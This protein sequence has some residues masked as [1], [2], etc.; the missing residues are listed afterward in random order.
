MNPRPY[1][2]WPLHHPLAPHPSPL[3][4]SSAQGNL[5]EN[6]FVSQRFFRRIF[7]PRCFGDLPA[8]AAR[9]ARPTPKLHGTAQPSW[10]D[11]LKKI[12][13]T[14][15][16]TKTTHVGHA[17]VCMTHDA[18]KKYMQSVHRWSFWNMKEPRNVR[19]GEIGPE[20]FGA[21]QIP[22]QKTWLGLGPKLNKR[23]SLE[24]SPP[25]KTHLEDPLIF[26]KDHIFWLHLLLK[27]KA[28]GVSTIERQLPGINFSKI[29]KTW[30]LKIFDYAVARNWAPKWSDYCNTNDQCCD[31]EI[32]P[33]GGPNFEPLPFT[34][35][36][37]TCHLSTTHGFS[38]VALRWGNRRAAFG[39]RMLSCD[40]W[41]SRTR[42]NSR[43]KRFKESTS[44]TGWEIGHLQVCETGTNAFVACSKK[45]QTSMY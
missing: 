22:P 34:S 6:P 33:N 11:D 26:T 44:V 38:L 25:T 29:L 40:V 36:Y 21:S 37:H 4:L 3:S 18:N 24:T 9:A 17:D 23:T 13:R 12:T 7:S 19:S 20:S 16:C 27:P 42:I 15:K 31:L 43:A 30:S 2:P 8:L 39:S 32:S 45:M 14:K 5:V 41:P 10:S 1:R 28:A 35:I